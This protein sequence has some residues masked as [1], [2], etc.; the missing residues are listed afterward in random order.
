MI[1]AIS[2]IQQEPERSLKT[3]IYVKERA[4]KK[5]IKGSAGG[6]VRTAFD[7]GSD[8]DMT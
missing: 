6:Y 8:I 5:Q 1:V 3:A 2:W 4:R 7:K